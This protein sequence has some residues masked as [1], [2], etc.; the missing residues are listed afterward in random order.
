MAERMVDRRAN[1]LDGACHSVTVVIAIAK[2]EMRVR[3]EQADR[4][5][6]G[7]VAAVE[8]QLDAAAGGFIKGGAHRAVLAV[9]IADDGDFHDV[10]MRHRNAAL[11]AF[12]NQ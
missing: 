12:P 4:I 5:R 3:R 1:L 6:V 8:D 2:H 10:T 9:S 11:G 7:D